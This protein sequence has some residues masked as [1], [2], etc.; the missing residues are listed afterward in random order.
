MIEKYLNRSLE[1]TS[2]TEYFDIGFQQKLFF[3]KARPIVSVTS[4]YEDSTGLWDGSENEITTDDYFR[5]DSNNSVNLSVAR[6]Y[7]ENNALRLIYS[8]GLAYHAVNSEFIISATGLTGTPA[9][10][11][12]AIGQSS[13]A[14]GVVVSWTV[15][16][17]V[18][19]IE[20]Y[21]GKFTSTEVIK[22]FVLEDGSGSSTFTG[23][24][25]SIS[26]Q[27]LAETYP[28]IVTACEIQTRYH[29]RHMNDFENVGTNKDGATMR[30]FDYI[31]QKM[32]FQP[33]VYNLLQPYKAVI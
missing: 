8:G 4:L 15:A 30:R 33:E 29:F 1:I 10:G 23:T 2:R 6:E 3:V 14:V 5:G 21:Y 28:E 16:T 7:V 26:K 19:I 25:S 27:S 20:N 17:K 9:V 13:G 12:Y 31:E 18:L 24:V 11:N 32:P 22:T